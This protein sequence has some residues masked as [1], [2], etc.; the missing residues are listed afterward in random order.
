MSIVN[1]ESILKAREL[2]ENK[3]YDYFEAIW[4]EINKDGITIENLI[5]L[6]NGFYEYSNNDNYL[7]EC[8]ESTIFKFFEEKSFEDFLDFYFTI[9]KNLF[10]NDKYSLEILFNFLL[11]D[12]KNV[13]AVKMR[14]KTLNLPNLKIIIYLI[15]NIIEIGKT[16]NFY[17]VYFENA[18]EIMDYLNYNI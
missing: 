15:K 8:I 2:K 4:A 5:I 14:A 10:S 7:R 11:K 12:Q 9:Q 16:D 17:E 3:D 13:E 1:K 6:S 18:L